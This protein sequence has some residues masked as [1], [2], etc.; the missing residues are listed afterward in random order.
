MVDELALRRDICEVARRLCLAGL[1]PG[2]DG[3]LSIKLREDEILLTPSRVWKGYMRPD[4]IIKVDSKGRVISGNLPPTLE[5]AMHLAA[6][7]ERP[8]I[9]AVVHAHPSF[10]TAFTLAGSSIPSCV[11]PEIE[12][13]FGGE[14]PVAPYATPATPE[15]ADSIRSIIHESNVV[16]L[17]HH[18]ALSVGVDI[19]QAGIRLE[20]V[21][22]AARTIF[23]AR[24]LGG[25]QRL[26]DSKVAPLREIHER[27]VAAERSVYR[28]AGLE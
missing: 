5:T 24:Q 15:L 6:Y 26:P 27:L 28:K 21:E 12:V 7:E 9:R 22:S 16:L 8:D 11:L 1:L 14:I 2:S 10:C 18:G 13:L 4:D 3:N 19:Y 25:E 23:Y 17:P 20:H